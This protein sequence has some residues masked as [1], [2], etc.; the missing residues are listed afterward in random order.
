VMGDQIDNSPYRLFR[1][2]VNESQYLAVYY[3]PT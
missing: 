2:N 3:K 1:V